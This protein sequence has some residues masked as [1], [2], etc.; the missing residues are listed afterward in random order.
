[1]TN[2]DTRQQLYN[3]GD[4]GSFAD[5]QLPLER[6]TTLHGFFFDLDPGLLRPGNP[7]FPPDDDP[8]RFFDLVRAVLDRHPLGRV[9]EVRA[10]GTGLH[11]ITWLDPPV[12]LS[13]AAAQAKWGSFVRTVQMTLPTDLH[14][15]GITGLTRAVG[16]TNSKNGAVVEVLRGGT[17]VAA[18]AVEEFMARLDRAPFKEI[19]TVLLGGTGVDPCP[20]CLGQGS[21]LDVLDHVGMCYSCGKVKLARLLDTIYAPLAKAGGDETTPAAG[22]QVTAVPTTPARKARAKGGKAAGRKA[23]KSAAGRAKAD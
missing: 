4:C 17:P 21:R 7:L 15:P 8:K 9:A 12:E 23:R 22:E 18:T 5:V 1:V 6:I 19:G 20:V 16:S 10:T 2:C 13:T 3:R 11:V 14:A